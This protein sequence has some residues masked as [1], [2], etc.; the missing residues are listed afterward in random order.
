MKDIKIN[1]IR[2]LGGRAAPERTQSPAK[3]PGADFGKALATAQTQ[4]PDM[5]ALKEQAR[6]VIENFEKDA[7]RFNE[8]MQASQTQ[9]RLIQS[10]MKRKPDSEA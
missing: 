3:K 4:A 1:Q 7:A 9:A 8:L 5:A 6:A 2:P 10:M